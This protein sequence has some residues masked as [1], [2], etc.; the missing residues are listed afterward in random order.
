MSGFAATLT[1][2]DIQDVSAY[3]SQLSENRLKN[4]DIK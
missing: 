4:L 3:Y 1:E 2:K